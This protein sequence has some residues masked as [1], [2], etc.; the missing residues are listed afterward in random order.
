MTKRRNKHGFSLVE[1]VIALSV[2]VIVS[3]SALSVTLS[4]TLTKVTALAKGDAQRFA[5]SVWECFK[6]S[7]DEAEFISQLA[8]AEDVTLGEGVSGEDGFT[9]YTYLSERYGYTVDLSVKFSAT[10]TSHLTVLCTD[11]DGEEII[12]FSYRKGGGV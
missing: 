3:L 4:S 8:F 11:D 7:D 12:S 9:S 5:D 2:I 10:D 6:V 1:V